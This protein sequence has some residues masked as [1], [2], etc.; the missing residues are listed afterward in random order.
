[1]CASAGV[2]PHGPKID[3]APSSH[4]CTQYRV[5]CLVGLIRRLQGW[6]HISIFEEFARFAGTKA[7]DEEVSRCGR[8][9]IGLAHAEADGRDCAAAAPLASSLKYSICPRSRLTL[10]TNRIGCENG[11]A[12][13][14]GWQGLALLL[15][16]VLCDVIYCTIVMIMAM[17]SSALLTTPPALLQPNVSGRTRPGRALPAAG[18]P[19]STSPHPLAT[20]PLLLRFES[21]SRSRGRSCKGKREV[22]QIF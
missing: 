19:I 2:V 8:A 12:G 16:S 9:R 17:M 10:R 18:T 6:S 22:G 4:H 11:R 20:L 7:V 3:T 5:G 21:R 14:C 15:P 13:A 1:M